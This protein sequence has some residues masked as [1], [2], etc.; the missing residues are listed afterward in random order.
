MGN[1]DAKLYFGSLGEWAADEAKPVVTRL[2][3]D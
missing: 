2:S 1:A 3:F